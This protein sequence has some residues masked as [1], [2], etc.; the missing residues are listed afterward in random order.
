MAFG[1]ATITKSKLVLS[2]MKNRVLGRT[3]VAFAFTFAFEL[4][5]NFVFDVFDNTTLVTTRQTSTV[6][7][8]HGNVLHEP[9]LN[10]IWQSISPHSPTFVIIRDKRASRANDFFLIPKF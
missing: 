8:S 2:C 10:V 6:T 3:S 9:V 5:F 1:M 4:E 7:H